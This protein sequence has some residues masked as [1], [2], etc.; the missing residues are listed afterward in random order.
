MTE[1][2]TIYRASA[3]GV[4]EIL[5]CEPDGNGGYQNGTWTSGATWAHSH[6]MGREYFLDCADAASKAEELRQKKIASLEK[7]LAKLKAAGPYYVVSEP[8]E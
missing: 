3:Q 4:D 2:V 8:K 6:Q 1:T 7:Q 5:G